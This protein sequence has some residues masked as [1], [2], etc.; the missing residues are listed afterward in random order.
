MLACSVILTRM[1]HGQHSNAMAKAA[2]SG[3]PAQVVLNY[4]HQ[5]QI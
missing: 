4:T 1:L 5:G 2:S 3:N